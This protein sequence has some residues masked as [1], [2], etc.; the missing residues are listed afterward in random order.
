MNHYFYL[1]TN[2]IYRKIKTN[3][4]SPFIPHYCYPSLYPNIVN[5]NWFGNSL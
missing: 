4:D 5:P 1:L 2:K 3:I